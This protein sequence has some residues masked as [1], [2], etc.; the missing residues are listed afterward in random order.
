MIYFS[1]TRSPAYE[2]HLT[3]LQILDKTEIVERY[4]ATLV[5]YRIISTQWI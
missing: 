5:L 4:L 3:I 1:I 2:P